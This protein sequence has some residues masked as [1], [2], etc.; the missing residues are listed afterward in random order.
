MLLSK[1]YGFLI[2]FIAITLCL[3]ATWLVLYYSE[4]IQRVLGE[5][6]TDIMGKVLGM[7]LAAIAVNL[8]VQGILTLAQAH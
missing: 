7:F 4:L 1:D 2:P 5:V 8:I 6:V 3:I